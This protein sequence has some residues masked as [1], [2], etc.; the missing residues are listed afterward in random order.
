[1]QALQ[2]AAGN[3]TSTFI[4]GLTDAITSGKSFGKVLEDITKQ[5]G[6]MI[7]KLTIEF[8]IREAMQALLFAANGAAFGSGGNVLPFAHGAAFDASGITKFANGG[9][10]T[11]P[12]PF[13]YGGGRLGV[14]GE[15]GA[16]AVMPLTRVGRDLGVKAT[17]LAPI[18]Q[19]I[20][21]RGAGAPPVKV[22]QSRGQD[23]RMVIRATIES[24]IKRMADNGTL[25]STLASNY[26]VKRRGDSD[27]Q[28]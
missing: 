8:A 27:D 26:G 3:M 21:N 2:D 13:Q 20:D 9:V 7:L 10:V 24:E 16:E 28:P 19:I 22:E 4:E 18:V 11:S 6:E 14:M 12:T 5:I 15:R 23:G 25:D 1:M 17:G